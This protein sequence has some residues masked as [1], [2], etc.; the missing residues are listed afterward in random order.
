MYKKYEHKSTIQI[1][2]IPFINFV[3]TFL[4]CSFPKNI[5]HIETIFLSLSMVVMNY[6]YTQS[7]LKIN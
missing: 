3:R 2:K 6:I 4:F 5:Y 1:E 7:K